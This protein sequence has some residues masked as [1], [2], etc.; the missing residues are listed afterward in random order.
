MKKLYILSAFLLIA[1]ISQA[2]YSQLPE[3]LKFSRTNNYGTARSAA[4]S[5]AFGAL[6]GDLS[7]MS[8]NPAGVGVFR[9]SEVSI[10]PVLN[11]AKTKSGNRSEQTTSFQLGNFGGVFS[12]Y[13]PNFDWKGFNFG[14]SYTNLNNFNRDF[15]QYVSHSNSSFLELV[16]MDAYNYTP[17]ELNDYESYAGNTIAGLAYQTYLIDTISSNPLEY[18]AFYGYNS[19]IRQR[20]QIKE[21]G[22]QGEYA[23]SFGTNYKDKLYLG[24]TIGIQ[25]FRYKMHSIYTEAANEENPLTSYDYDEYLKVEGTGVNFKLG[26]IYRPIP[27]LRIGAAVHTP[28]F[29]NVTETFQNGMASYFNASPD[30]EGF[31]DFSSFT[32]E[33]SYSYNLKTPW[34]ALFSLA[35]VL[36]QKA[37]LSVDY[38]FAKY[39]SIRL[40]DGEDGNDFY[41]TEDSYGINDDIKHALKAAHTVRIGAEYRFNSTFSLRAGYNIQTS[42]SSKMKELDYNIQGISAG[43]GANF[44]VFYCDAAYV[45]TSAKNTTRFYNYLD[46]DPALNISA[47]PVTNKMRGN[48]ARI[49]LGVRF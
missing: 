33:T 35:T 18:A 6:G 3:I 26:V 10:T 4:M 39:S 27:E 17:E 28:T 24:A 40:S 45:H 38:E 25:D 44:G 42:A 12:F 16:L 11:V 46:V 13:S 19:N 36:K 48:E 34:K 43:F 49:T 47:T 9:K 15:N 30:P 22:Y 23:F 21:D 32:S 29:Y 5:G 37:I 31:L 1:G 2:Q 41:D 14:I 7:T 20:K 8:S